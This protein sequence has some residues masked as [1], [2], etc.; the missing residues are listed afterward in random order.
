MFVLL[1]E[2]PDFA[3]KIDRF[4]CLS[5]VTFFYRTLKIIRDV[6]PLSYILNQM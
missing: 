6:A 4:I 3:D 1:S 2:Q 5:G